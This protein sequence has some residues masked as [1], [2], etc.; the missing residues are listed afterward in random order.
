MADQNTNSHSHFDILGVHISAINLSQAVATIEQ[1]MEN[2][3]RAYVCV[4]DAHGII[5]SQRDPVLKQIH[6]SAG[7]VTPDG[8]PLVWLAHFYGHRHVERVYG[9]DLML[10]VC[11]HS[12]ITKARHF[13]YGGREGVADQLA[14][15]LLIRFPYLQI[16]GTYTPPMGPPSPEEDRQIT[17]SINNAQ[18]DIIWVG[19][20]TPM[21]E[22][23]MADHIDRLN[24]AVLIGVGAAFDLNAG[25][26]KRAPTWMQQRGLEWL[27]R[28]VTEPQ[29][30][31]RRYIKVI[32][33]F[34]VLITLQLLGLKSFDEQDDSVL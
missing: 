6:N 20:S 8:M 24:P 15:A 14:A 7:M 3:Q 22:H 13:F 11:E 4:R 28:L 18:A 31:W 16:A 26:K 17:E 12:N 5:E 19:L 25:L 32:P 29:R 33:L 30:L 23:W 27:F 1:W 10:A 34:T 2:L 21:Q 9:P